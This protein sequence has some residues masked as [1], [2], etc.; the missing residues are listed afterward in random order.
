[1]TCT[2]SGR[3]MM[4]YGSTNSPWQEYFQENI[5]H[6]KPSLYASIL[7]P[8]KLSAWTAP[9]QQENTVLHHEIPYHGKVHLSETQTK[10]GE[11]QKPIR[12]NTE[13]RPV[14]SDLKR[15]EGGYPATDAFYN[16][17]QFLYEA[18][19]NGELPDGR[20]SAKTEG[21]RKLKGKRSARKISEH[22]GVKSRKVTDYFPVRRSSRKCK[23]ELMYEEKKQIDELIISGKEEGLKVDYIDGKGRGVLATRCFCRGEYIVEYHGDLIEFWDAKR[24]E[25][26]YAQDPSTGCYMYYFHY[27]GKTYCVD[28]TKETHRLGRLINHSKNGNC[29]TKLHDI[30]GVPHLILVASRDIEAGEELLYDYGDRSKA[31]LEAHPW[32]KH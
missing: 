2:L 24:R 15:K 23:A 26:L 11:K 20:A 14:K 9:P 4:E 18:T 22:R 6:C 7:R 16:T 1:M 27:L 28:A 10:E 32:L 12:S 25:A 8:L 19:L 29:H 30:S 31:S 3:F 17:N 21:Q 13:A 5:F